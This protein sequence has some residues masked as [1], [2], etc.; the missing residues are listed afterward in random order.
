MNELEWTVR[1]INYDS[2]SKN[3]ISVLSFIFF[4][5]LSFVIRSQDFQFSVLL[6]S[7]KYS[8]KMDI[9]DQYFVVKF[10]LQ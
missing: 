1:V 4:L 5:S 6:D 2:N 3:Q 8:S 7:L 10:I 9:L